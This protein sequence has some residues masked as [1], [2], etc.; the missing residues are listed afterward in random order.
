MKTNQLPN[1]HPGQTLLETLQDLGIT[2][3]RLAVALRI[4]HS[5][6]TAIIKGRQGI[7]ATTAL[8]LGRY[9]GTTP[10]YWLNLQHL[11]DLEKAER[12]IAEELA[13][14]SPVAV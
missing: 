9:F 11:H 8:K 6:V 4:P 3:Y 14:I 2:Q 10:E 12:S 7:T 5:R 13:A 1:P